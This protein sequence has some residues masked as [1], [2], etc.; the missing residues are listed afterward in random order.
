MWL[1]QKMRFKGKFVFRFYYLDV[2]VTANVNVSVP[3]KA[4]QSA[5]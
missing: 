2:H 5:R 3:E 4:C 1:D